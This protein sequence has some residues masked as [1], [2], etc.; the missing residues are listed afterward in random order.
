MIG[1]QGIRLEITC[2][3]VLHAISAVRSTN[4]TD[5]CTLHIEWKRNEMYHTSAHRQTIQTISHSK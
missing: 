5:F 4:A 1:I 2:H 3:E